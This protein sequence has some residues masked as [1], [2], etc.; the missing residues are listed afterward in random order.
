MS[1][2]CTAYFLDA[3][4]LLLTEHVI[5]LCVYAAHACSFN[6]K[7]DYR[8]ELI[9]IKVLYSPPHERSKCGN[10]ATTGGSWG[11]CRLIR[12]GRS[13][14]SFH[15]KYMVHYFAQ[16]S[17]YPSTRTVCAIMCITPYQQQWIGKITDLLWDCKFE[18]ISGLSVCNG[19]LECK[20]MWRTFLPSWPGFSFCF[21]AWS[22]PI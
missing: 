4:A 12:D 2:N 13:W 9:I 7:S 10:F 17:P 19:R 6:Y 22:Q 21:F 15:E 16:N 14:C 18:R 20:I 8:K 1:W 11:L 5:V 3:R